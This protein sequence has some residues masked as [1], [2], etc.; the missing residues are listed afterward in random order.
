MALLVF[1]SSVLDINSN[2][3]LSTSCF[4]LVV[5]C[6]IRGLNIL[7]PNGKK[8]AKEAIFD[9]GF[10][11]TYV[12]LQKSVRGEDCIALKAYPNDWQLYAYI[13]TDYWPYNEYITFLGST[14]DEPTAKDFADLLE[15]R[16]EFKMN[17]NMRR[18]DRMMNRNQ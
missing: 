10:E 14:K 12:L 11:E 16:D 15:N 2:I 3:H 6:K 1:F 4:A 5:L 17:K 7:A 13:E 9:R 8:L 18:M